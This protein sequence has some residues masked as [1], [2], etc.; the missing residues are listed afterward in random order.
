VI[1]YYVGGREFVGLAAEV[2]REHGFQVSYKRPIDNRELP[3]MS[4]QVVVPLTLIGAT[5]GLKLA[6][7]AVNNRLRPIRARIQVPA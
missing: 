2:Y 6:T 1:V 5:G 7:R 4:A 3:A